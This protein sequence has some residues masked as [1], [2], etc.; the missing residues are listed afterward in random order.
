MGRADLVESF[1]LV[2]ALRPAAELAEPVTAPPCLSDPSAGDRY[3][4][5]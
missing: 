2:V 3:P 5:N 4:G 1:F